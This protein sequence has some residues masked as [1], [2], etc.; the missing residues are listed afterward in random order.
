MDSSREAKEIIEKKQ[1]NLIKQLSVVLRQTPTERLDAGFRSSEAV[2]T[3][4]RDL[5][6]RYHKEVDNLL[7]SV[8]E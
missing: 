1:N 5:V 6:N 8:P 2:I 7:D 4:C 3:F